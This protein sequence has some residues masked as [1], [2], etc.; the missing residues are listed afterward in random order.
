VVSVSF[1]HPGTP[2]ALT[3]HTLPAFDAPPA[4]TYPSL[5]AVL[6]FQVFVALITLFDIVIL[7]PAVSLFCLLSSPLSTYNISA[8][9][10]RLEL[11][12]DFV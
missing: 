2:L 6:A 5:V 12:S 9:L 11:I 7:L 4:A 8:L 10:L 1:I 3:F